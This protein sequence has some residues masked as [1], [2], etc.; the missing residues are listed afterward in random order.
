MVEIGKGHSLEK[1]PRVMT[2]TVQ[3]MLIAKFVA[4]DIYS[5]LQ[6]VHIC[7]ATIIFRNI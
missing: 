5:Q 2:P 1:G 3:R 6:D 4:V 7:T